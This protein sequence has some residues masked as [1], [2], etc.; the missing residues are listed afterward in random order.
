MAYASYGNP[1]EMLTYNYNSNSVI[2]KIGDAQVHIPRGTHVDTIIRELEYV[3]NRQLH[4]QTKKN[5][6]KWIYE[7]NAYKLKADLGITNKEN[8]KNEEDKKLKDLIAHYYSKG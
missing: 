4:E 6:N 3:F 8:L 1:C 7:Y 2:V 5:Q